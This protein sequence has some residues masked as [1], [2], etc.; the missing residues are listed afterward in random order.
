MNV[1]LKMLALL[2]PLSAIAVAVLIFMRFRHSPDEALAFIAA[3]VY[4][5][6]ML[7]GGGRK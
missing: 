5:Q 3:A 7:D 6:I 4:L 1:L 2:A